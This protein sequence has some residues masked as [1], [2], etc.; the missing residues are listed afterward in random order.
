MSMNAYENKAMAG[1]Q[2]I[3]SVPLP[4]D[5]TDEKKR[6]VE[7]R[8]RV[9]LGSG[10]LKLSIAAWTSDKDLYDWVEGET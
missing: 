8:L 1:Q 5:I 6:N 3:K 4:R 2:S 7:E 9:A 10:H